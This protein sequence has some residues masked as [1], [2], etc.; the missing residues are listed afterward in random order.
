MSMHLGIN[1]NVKGFKVLV[2]DGKKL[3]TTLDWYGG[4]SNSHTSPFEYKGKMY[5]VFGP[6]H[7]F[8]NIEQF[9]LFEMQEVAIAK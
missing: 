4:N 2:K 5:V 9:R 1:D 7:T 3:V 8:Q 6:F